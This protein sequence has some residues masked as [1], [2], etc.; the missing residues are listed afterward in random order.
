MEKKQEEGKLKSGNLA[1]RDEKFISKII[2]KIQNQ[3]VE[4]LSLAQVLKSDIEDHIE[5]RIQ[6]FFQ[7]LILTYR[8]FGVFKEY[9]TDKTY[10]IATPVKS[11]NKEGNNQQALMCKLTAA[12]CS[13]LPNMQFVSKKKQINHFTCA[14]VN[15]KDLSPVVYGAYS[16]FHNSWNTTTTLPRFVNDV[17]STIDMIKAQQNLLEGAT[18]R[19]YC[20]EILNYNSKEVTNPRMALRR[21]LLTLDKLITQLEAN[22]AEKDA[23]FQYVLRCYGNVVKDYIRQSEK[24]EFFHKISFGAIT[25][26]EIE[27]AQFTTLGIHVRIQ[28]KFQSSIRQCFNKFKEEA[29]EF[30]ELS[31][32]SA[33]NMR[34]KGVFSKCLLIAM[35]ALYYKKC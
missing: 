9:H 32:P 11:Q 24:F 21:F 8:T 14:N 5:M 6:L 33:R 10:K 28:M 7:Q 23:S 26:M 4:P 1:E 35:S 15:E 13:T 29:I 17:D 31:D 19:D 22:S 12:H 2:K 34:Q 20:I 27:K 30:L 16:Y 3:K 18:F 25:K